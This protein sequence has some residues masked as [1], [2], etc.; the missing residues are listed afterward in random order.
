[1]VS[2][3]K[4]ILVQKLTKA[5]QDHPVIALVNM[6]NLPAKQLQNMREQLRKKEIIVAM[7]RK[8]LLQLSLKNSKKQNIDALIQKIKGMPALLLSKENPFILA[9][10]LDKS[11]SS[12]PAKAGQEAPRDIVVP[13]GPTS[14]A[15]GPIISEL[16]NVGIKTKVDAGKLTIIEDTIV[17]KE[18][19][20]ISR[21]LAEMLK[22]LDIQPMEIG[23]N[24]VAAWENEIIFEPKQLRIDETEYLNNI[25][26]AF[27]EAF[28]LS[29]ELAYPTKDNI[30]L[31]LQ[32]AFRESKTISLETD[33]I[34]DLTA[35]EILAK[36]E[37]QALALKN[38]AGIEG[39]T[40][41]KP[42]EEKKEEVKEEEKPA[43]EV[44]EELKVEEKKPEPEVK[45]EAPV[46]EA[47]AE[48]EKQEEKEEEKSEEK[49]AEEV[50]EEKKE[51]PAV[52]ESKDE[53]SDLV[54]ETFVEEEKPEE[55][56]EQQKEEKTGEE[57]P[58]EEEKQ[59]E[60]TKET[61]VE[62]EKQETKEDI[63]S[64]EDMIQAVK[65]K[66]KEE[67]IPESRLEEKTSASEMIKATKEEFD[68]KV[69]KEQKPSA[70]SLVDEEN[71]E[72]EKEKEKIK[73]VKEAENLF[74][75]LKKQGTL[76]EED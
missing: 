65:D 14:F 59:E 67:Q 35:E 13:A 37:R 3:K 44:K 2:E 74:E 9:Q 4:K 42:Q 27:Q 17:A 22:R 66:F 71:K 26:N 33:F 16:A 50:P 40:E 31:L 56:E 64:A 46:E 75:K 49:P 36:T 7:A 19:D 25:T 68:P 23:L 54:E 73:D 47:P 41:S 38:E 69:E 11:K 1:M 32:K 51:E 52:G 62:E 30:E 12:A 15:P 5:I 10:I 24:L 72:S 53:E 29:V 20:V 48:E 21:P 57:A 28:N 18:G 39:S 6:E 70:E 58:K 63:P 61:K 60:V 8:K 43:E 55:V 45:A 76:R 34:T